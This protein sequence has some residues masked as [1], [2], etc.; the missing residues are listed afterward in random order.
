[1]DQKTA[2]KI[3]EAIG[4]AEAEDDRLNVMDEVTSACE[5]QIP[6]PPKK[7]Y[8]CRRC[9]NVAERFTHYCDF[10]GQ[11]FGVEDF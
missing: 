5:K 10:C 9:G 8:E 7:N 1:M 3:Y 4:K 11:Y 2:V 6:M